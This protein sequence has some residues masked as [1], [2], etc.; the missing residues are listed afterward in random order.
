MLSHLTTWVADHGALAVF[1]LMA[2][3]ALLPAGG[4]LIMLAAGAMAAGALGHAHGGLETY[5]VL[6]LAGTLGYLAGAMIGWWIGERGG[7]ALIERHGRWLHL[8]PDRFAR[9]EQWF[10][11][12]G[13]AAVFLGRLTPVVR[14]FISIPAGALGTPPGPYIVLSLAGSAIWCFGWA[15]VGWAVGGS[16]ES[17]HQGFR[18]ADVA[19][20]AALLAAAVVFAVRRRRGGLQRS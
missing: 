20:V 5:L 16:Y 3:D 6:S 9:A 17:V 15:A 1:V 12:H 14:S 11:R 10:A 4:E 18:Y 2:V 13:S 7:R 19:A 8:T